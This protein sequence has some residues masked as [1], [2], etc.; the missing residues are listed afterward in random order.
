MFGGRGRTA[1]QSAAKGAFRLDVFCMGLG[2]SNTLRNDRQDL[3]CHFGFSSAEK[4]K[5]QEIGC[6]QGLDSVSP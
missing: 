1:S 6:W 3:S 4:N 5:G 2:L